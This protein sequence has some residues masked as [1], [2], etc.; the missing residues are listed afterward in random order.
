M[1]PENAVKIF[2]NK[3]FAQKPDKV[4]L[5]LSGG[6]DSMVLAHILLK[7]KIPFA[8]AHCNYQLRGKES[9]MDEQMLTSFCQKNKILLHS[10]KFNTLAYCKQN[11]VGIQEGARNLRYDYF[12]DLCTRYKY[13]FICTAH[14]KNDFAETYLFNLFRGAG[15]KGLRG[16]LPKRDNLI[17]PMLDAEKK[18]IYTYAQKHQVPYREDQ[19]NYKN[20]YSRNYIRNEI[21]PE[22]LLLQPNFIGDIY[23]SGQDMQMLQ[24]YKMDQLASFEQQFIAR[25][26]NDILINITE[27]LRR[28]GGVNFFKIYLLELGFNKDAINNILHAKSGSKFFS[29]E[30]LLQLYKSKGIVTR[31]EQ[32]PEIHEQ[33]IDKNTASVVIGTKEYR[34]KRMP[35]VITAFT[36]G[37]LYFDA[38]LL[39]YPL[40]LRKWKPGDK[41]IPFGMTGFKKVSDLLTDLKIPLHIKNNTCVLVSGDKI[42]AVIPYRTDNRFLLTHHTR[43]V[44]CIYP[45]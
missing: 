2:F 42:A 36:P 25:E 4:L 32:L 38:D 43:S 28:P 44:L 26:E 18:E 21:I 35:P 39:T 17:R 24:Q 10:K 22:L 1:N 8:A 23:Q 12:K 7:L 30:Y 9:N 20:D 31:R 11:K 41:F 6:V 45:K 5:A 19:S 13:N 3:T 34:I 37:R 29:T 15:I 27:W 14:Q 33:L 40:L 16:I